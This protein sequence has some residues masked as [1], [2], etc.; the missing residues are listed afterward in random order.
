[1][2]KAIGLIFMLAAWSPVLCVLALVLPVLFLI[3]LV[4]WVRDGRP[5]LW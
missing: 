2:G 1:M 3:G 4:S 5:P